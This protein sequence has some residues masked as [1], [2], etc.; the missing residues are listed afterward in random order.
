MK[1]KCLVHIYSGLLWKRTTC[2]LPLSKWAFNVGEGCFEG[3]M[4]AWETCRGCTWGQSGWAQQWGVGVGLEGLRGPSQPQ[5]S[6]VLLC[7]SCYK[8][9]LFNV[10]CKKIFTWRKKKIFIRFVCIKSNKVLT[11]LNQVHTWHTYRK[12]TSNTVKINLTWSPLLITTFFLIYIYIDI[13]I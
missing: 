9:F 2:A 4:G 11:D 5:G 8:A 10:E 1:I 13:G 7:S 6:S 12:K 3:S